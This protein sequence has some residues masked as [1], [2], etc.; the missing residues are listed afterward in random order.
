L[1]RHIYRVKLDEL[2]EDEAKL[3]KESHSEL[4]SV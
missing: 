1:A 4:V 3:M 2:R